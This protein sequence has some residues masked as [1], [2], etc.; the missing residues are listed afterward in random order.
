MTREFF[1]L[2]SWDD[3]N[4]FLEEDY[5]LETTNQLIENEDV[6]KSELCRELNKAIF[7][8]SAVTQSAAEWEAV[9]D[10]ITLQH[11]VTISLTPAKMSKSI[12]LGVDLGQGVIGLEPKLIGKTSS[13]AP[14]EVSFNVKKLPPHHSLYSFSGRNLKA[15]IKI[16]KVMKPPFD[17]PE[18]TDS[19]DNESFSLKLQYML[20]HIPFNSAKDFAK[21]LSNQTIQLNLGKKIK[22]II[23]HFL[24]QY[25]EIPKKFKSTTHKQ[26]IEIGSSFDPE[27]ELS[28]LESIHTVF[29]DQK[30]RY[31][32]QT[33]I[34]YINNLFDERYEMILENI[35]K[36]VKIQ[37]TDIHENFKQFRLLENENQRFEALS[38]EYSKN[39]S[40]GA[41]EEVLRRQKQD[42]VKVEREIIRKKRKYETSKGI[43]LMQEMYINVLEK[44]PIFDYAFKKMGVRLQDIKS[45]MQANHISIKKD[46]EKMAKSLGVHAK[47]LL[48][49]HAIY[50]E[51]EPDLEQIISLEDLSKYSQED[52][53]GVLNL[54]PSLK[55]SLGDKEVNATTLL[56]QTLKTDI[57]VHEKNA[58]KNYVEQNPSP[59]NNVTQRFSQQLEQYLEVKKIGNGVDAIKVFLQKE[60][61]ILKAVIRFASEQNKLST[62]FKSHLKFYEKLFIDPFMGLVEDANDPELDELESNYIRI[63]N[64]LKIQ[65]NLKYNVAEEKALLSTFKQIN[66]QLSN[67]NL[68]NVNIFSQQI[69]SFMTSLTKHKD[70]ISGPLMK[71]VLATYTVFLMGSSRTKNLA[72]KA[73][74]DS[75]IDLQKIKAER[76]GL[77]DK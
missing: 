5:G 11:K 60:I 75:H 56:Q 63:S 47:H 16:L 54:V 18:L 64:A 4:E 52:I 43:I 51:T 58:F 31:Q 59:R 65:L 76:V 72:K 66:S 48:I 17:L 3:I 77:T 35:L 50:S 70:K 28:F 27:M 25:S 14:M 30:N 44:N 1:P 46:L 22:T 10:A 73:T 68:F 55:E 41:G 7:Q 21:S 45:Q 62:D 71:K 8:A 9:R 19:S 53:E 2:E 29:E 49:Q 36:Q 38:E 74:G 69:R 67:D 34:K 39:K 40:K 37:Q 24:E 23:V 42:L 13:S 32:P 15:T 6:K 12:E 26:I 61:V 33:F 57:P 20:R